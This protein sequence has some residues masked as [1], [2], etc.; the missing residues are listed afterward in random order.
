MGSIW[1]WMQQIEQIVLE[2][3]GSARLL[4]LRNQSVA[5]DIIALT[6][7][8]QDDTEKQIDSAL[9]KPDAAHLSFS[10]EDGLI[11][12]QS[13]HAMDYISLNPLGFLFS[14]TVLPRRRTD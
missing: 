10:S 13:E 7:T 1:I 6:D 11:A 8:P 9:E 5:E 4:L 2:A 14:L 12:H 3:L